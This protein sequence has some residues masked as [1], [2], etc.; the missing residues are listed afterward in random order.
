[1]QMDEGLDTG[2]MLA[3]HTEVIAQTDTT[4]TLNDRLAALGGD[5]L[6]DTLERLLAGSVQATPQP[7]EGVTYAEKIS[8]AESALDWTQPADV[9]AR[10]VRAFNPFPGAHTYWAD[11]VLKIWRADS[12]VGGGTQ[13]PGTVVAATDQ[14]ILVQTADG[15]LALNQLQSPSGKRLDAADWLRGHI[16]HP[17]TVLGTSNARG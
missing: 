6:V 3:M 11:D 2:D 8:K 5:L 9:L 14:G 7:S 1:M 15:L 13:R 4:G 12:P 16:L 17:G 10:K